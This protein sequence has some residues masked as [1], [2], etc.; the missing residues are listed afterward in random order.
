[1][2]DMNQEDELLKGLFESSEI[3]APS[4]ITERVMHRIDV[5]PKAFE[6]QPLIS[7]KVWMI[8]GGAFAMIMIYL[9]WN[10]GSNPIELPKVAVWLKD[11]F[12]GIGNNF[13]IKSP[14]LPQLP[15]IPSTMLIALAA[16]NVIGVYLM[17]SFRWGRRIFK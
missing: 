4:D 10:S 11:S 3:Q 15:Q 9:L 7:K 5:N 6:Y 14:S 16:I 17:I 8:M 13:N 1:M 12:S 2:T